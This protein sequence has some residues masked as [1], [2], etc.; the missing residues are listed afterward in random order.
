MALF[1]P[2]K[3]TY[4]SGVYE[5]LTNNY[6]GRVC[7]IGNPLITL[8]GSVP[9]QALTFE[10]QNVVQVFGEYESTSMKFQICD[11]FGNLID[12]SPITTELMSE[13]LATLKPYKKYIFRLL[14]SNTTIGSPT[15]YL[16]FEP[17]LPDTGGLVSQFPNNNII[18][19]N[20]NQISQKED[21]Y[22]NNVFNVSGI[23]IKAGDSFSLGTF[24]NSLVTDSNLYYLTFA[25]TNDQTTFPNVDFKTELGG[26]INVVITATR[27]VTNYTDIWT[28]AG[29]VFPATSF[30]SPLIITN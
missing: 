21:I 18:K 7:L 29:N 12:F 25:A 9:V 13:P 27:D 10:F 17:V 26:S 5:V 20:Y 16:N 1:M 2:I 14:A 28:I 22:G 23:D 4:T 19:T 30:V 11:E 8:A 3:L 24:I 6:K 15:W